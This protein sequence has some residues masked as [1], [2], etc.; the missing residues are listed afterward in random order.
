MQITCAKYHEIATFCAF[1]TNYN[2]RPTLLSRPNKA[3][4]KCPS[5]RPQKGSSISMKFG[6]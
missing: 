6:I 4:L 2:F 1:V 5:D 3:D